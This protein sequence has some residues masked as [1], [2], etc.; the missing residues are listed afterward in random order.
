M[1]RFWATDIFTLRATCGMILFSRKNN[2]YHS[3][4]VR[5]FSSFDSLTLKFIRYGK[6][7]QA[8]EVHANTS[9][10]LSNVEV[11]IPH[12]YL[13]GSLFGYPSFVSHI[14]RSKQ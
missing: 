9:R 11:R 8:S 4:Y 2:W 5:F 14:K 7:W 12:H 6:A 10:R 13:Q 1:N 3:R